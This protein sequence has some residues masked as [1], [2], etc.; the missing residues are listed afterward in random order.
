MTLKEI[1]D[2]LA[3]MSSEMD[4]LLD[5]ES[6]KS[7]PKTFQESLKKLDSLISELEDTIEEQKANSKER[8]D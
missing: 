1:V 3:E 8:E 5:D 4:M 7:F 2:G 6:V